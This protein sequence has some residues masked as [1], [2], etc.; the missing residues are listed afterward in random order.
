MAETAH[1]DSLE[2]AWLHRFH[3][4]KGYATA[5]T[6]NVTDAE[7]V[8]QEAVARTIRANPELPH[9]SDAHH[10]VLAAV[11]SVALQLFSQRSRRRSLEPVEVHG[12]DRVTDDPLGLLLAAEAQ[13][14]QHALAQRAHDA[15]TDLDPRLRQIV[16]L[17]VLREPPMKLRE[18]AAIQDAPLSTV[19]SRLRSALRAL[20]RT[21]S[22]EI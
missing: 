20:A 6:G 15:L 13:E 1:F 21:V 22:E 11:R 17:M 7:E 3:R 9:E 16:E 4:W 5:L 12:G 2:K 10:Y 8:I 18:V 19:H 14:R